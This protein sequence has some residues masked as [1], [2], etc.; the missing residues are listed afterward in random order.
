MFEKSDGRH[1]RQGDRKTYLPSPSAPEMASH[2]PASQGERPR[3]EVWTPAHSRSGRSRWHWLLL[4][5]VV[6][7][8]LAPFYNR[9]EPRLLGLPFFYWWQ[10]AF[11]LAAMA[12]IAVV[13]LA[14]RRRG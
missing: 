6:V 5:P 8:L 2:L 1:Q 12:V 9:I 14:T 7:P 10:M 3:P 4:I 11:V 13:T